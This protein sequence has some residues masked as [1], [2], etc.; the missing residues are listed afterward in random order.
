MKGKS[1]IMKKKK[2]ISVDVE[3]FYGRSAE[4]YKSDREE[5]N[6]TINELLP[7]VIEIGENYSLIIEEVGPSVSEGDVLGDNEEECS[8]GEMPPVDVLRP[9]TSP[10]GAGSESIGAKKVSM[11]LKVIVISIT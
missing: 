2:E 4:S 5:F 7:K 9:I 3:G 11:C 6:D 1:L 10:T 8:V